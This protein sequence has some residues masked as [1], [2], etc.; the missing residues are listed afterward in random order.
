MRGEGLFGHRHPGVKDQH[1]NLKTRRKL[2]SLGLTFSRLEIIVYMPH[3]F[4]QSMVEARA[5][6]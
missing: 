6:Q 5:N 2:L 3:S 4:S 1:Q